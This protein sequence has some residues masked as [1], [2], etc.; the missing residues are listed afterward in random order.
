[1]T[2]L[3]AA[4]ED[5]SNWSYKAIGER[6]EL[7]ER[8][9]T[10]W[11]HGLLELKNASY[12]HIEPDLDKSL[13]G[14]VRR[15]SQHIEHG[16]QGSP[17]NTEEPP[18]D[19]IVSKLDSHSRRVALFNNRHISW[20]HRSA[21]D[22]FF[23][24]TSQ[25]HTRQTN[26]LLNSYNDCD[27]TPAL[28]QGFRR[29]M[30]TLPHHGCT[31]PCSACLVNH[32]HVQAHAI[33]HTAVSATRLLG[34]CHDDALDQVF[35]TLLAWKH[36]GPHPE[37]ASDYHVAFRK[38][39]QSR[40]RLGEWNCPFEYR[41]PVHACV[42]DKCFVRFDL[43]TLSRDHTMEQ[44]SLGN[45][46]CNSLSGTLSEAIFWKCCV[47]AK[48]SPSYTIQRCATLHR[49]RSGGVILACM[50]EVMHEFPMRKLSTDE[51]R[52]EAN[53]LDQI[54]LWFNRHA[55]APDTNASRW[56]GI[57]TFES[58]SL[59]DLDSR[60][61]IQKIALCFSFHTRGLTQLQDVCESC[62]TSHDVENEKCSEKWMVEALASIFA[63]WPRHDL[64]LQLSQILAPR[65]ICV[66]ISRLDDD[67]LAIMVNVTEL[68]RINNTISM[69]EH[70]DAAS[71]RLM[72][73]DLGDGRIASHWISLDIA[74]RMR[75]HCIETGKRY[76]PGRHKLELDKKAFL[77]FAEDLL[78]DVHQN[79]ALLA[80]EKTALENALCMSLVDHAKCKALGELIPPYYSWSE[81]PQLGQLSAE[82]VETSDYAGQVEQERLMALLSNWRSAPA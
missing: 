78:Q 69:M 66:N 33:L 47:Q 1:V 46:T 71:L 35:T 24:P 13:Y 45:A 40:L 80:I 48:I 15:T 53:V 70:I 54:Q 30:L 37:P 36:H 60:V 22:F 44:V 25:S 10:H 20:L 12:E 72:L 62:T 18:T 50:L 28:V 19:W 81:Y 56:M 79:P 49:R 3:V 63:N 14:W 82:Q 6:C 26:D 61:G 5:I 17:R 8:R 2:L 27:V 39:R 29:L 55:S 4:Q 23:S 9:I 42:E 11:S 59:D 74:W 7:E 51:M 64:G 58:L 43:G 38:M 32:F 16:T 67:S 73:R 52:L 65:D 57:L 41:K 34:E 77:S 75:K 31:N 76:T 21:F 68:A